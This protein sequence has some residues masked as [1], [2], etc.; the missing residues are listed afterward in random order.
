[1]SVILFTEASSSG[2]GVGLQGGSA[3]NGGSTSMEQGSAFRLGLSGGGVGLHPGGSAQPPTLRFSGGQCSDRYASYWNAFLS[4]AVIYSRC[5][6][7]LG[8]PRHKGN[9]I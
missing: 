3:S 1:M 8:F 5:K 7:S 4:S 6:I 2:G 9:G